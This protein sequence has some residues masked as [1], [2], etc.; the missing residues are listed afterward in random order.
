MFCFV[1]SVATLC[2]WLLIFRNSAQ[3][4]FFFFFNPARQLVRS[5]AFDSP[6]LAYSSCHRRTRR[7]SQFGREKVFIGFQ[8]RSV[9]FMAQS[10]GRHE[11][12]RRLESESRDR[13]EE[14]LTSCEQSLPRLLERIA[15]V[16]LLELDAIRPRMKVIKTPLNAVLVRR[17]GLRRIP[18]LMPCVWIKATLEQVVHVNNGFSGVLVYGST[19]AVLRKSLCLWSRAV[20]SV[21]RTLNEPNQGHGILRLTL[22]LLTHGSSMTYALHM[23][24]GAG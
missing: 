16:L 6:S 10:V 7:R 23:F 18:Q 2:W 5:I 14:I 13:R 20:L 19:P 17:L 3:S 12:E 8:K 21:V 22:L 1:F 4:F 11:G 15:W 9:L 24:H